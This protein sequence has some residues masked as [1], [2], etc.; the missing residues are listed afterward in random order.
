MV[1]GTTADHNRW[2]PLLPALE[3]QFT[4]YTMDRR[5]RGAS[6]D[7]LPYAIQREF[8]DVAAVV[9]AIGGPVHVLGHSMGA[10]CSLEAALLTANVGKLI[11][12]EPPLRPGDPDAPGFLDALD[13]LIERGSREEALGR[14]LQEIVR[15]PPH[16]MELLRAVPAWKARVAAAHTVPRE[17]RIHETYRFEPARFARLQTSTL[18]LEGGDS[19]HFLKASIEAAHAALSNSQIVVMPGQQH[20][21]MDTA[22][23]L[24]LAEVL[25]FL[26]AP[27]LEAKASIPGC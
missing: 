20:V 19:P 26:H 23:D 12:Y 17:L 21:A 18:L 11:L 15:V 10:L 14:F 7:T 24:F 22:R 1:H 27:D 16:E 6:G 3:P 25:R 5:G 2:Q 13:Q 9:G 4:V 8:E